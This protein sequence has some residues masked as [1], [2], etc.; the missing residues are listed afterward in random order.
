M[1]KDTC[2][3]LVQLEMVLEALTF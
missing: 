3:G 2:K 1:N